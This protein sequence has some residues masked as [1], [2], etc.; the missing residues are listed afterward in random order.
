[1][2]NFSSLLAGY[3]HRLRSGTSHVQLGRPV[4][5][6]RPIAS[7]RDARSYIKKTTKLIIQH[8]KKGVMLRLLVLAATFRDINRNFWKDYELFQ[9][10]HGPASTLTASHT[11]CLSK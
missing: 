1:M 6:S 4:P 3:G 5:V 2:F 10:W 8:I 7:R 9:R 11:V